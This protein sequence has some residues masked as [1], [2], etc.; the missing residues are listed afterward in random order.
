MEIDK[1]KQ[2]KVNLIKIQNYNKKA[3]WHIFV[4]KKKKKK[5]TKNNIN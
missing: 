2:K 5:K 4:K 3:R 1:T